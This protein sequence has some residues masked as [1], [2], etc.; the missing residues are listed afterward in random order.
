MFR[1]RLE[2]CWELFQFGLAQEGT[3]HSFPTQ[4]KNS[5]YGLVINIKHTLKESPIHHQNY[6]ELKT[7]GEILMGD[8]EER[9]ED[10]GKG[11]FNGFNDSLDEVVRAKPLYR[12]TNTMTRSFR[13]LYAIDNYHLGVLV[14]PNSSYKLTN[15]SS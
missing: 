1:T 6:I 14:L 15:F 2:P 10:D 8:V 3:A 9:K 7:K 11:V 12:S 4:A 13:A 5:L